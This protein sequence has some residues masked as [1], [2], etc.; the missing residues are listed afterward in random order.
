MFDVYGEVKNILVK[1]I[2]VKNINK[3]AKHRFDITNLWQKDSLWRGK[4]QFVLRI[5][6]KTISIWLAI[7]LHKLFTLR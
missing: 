4:T 6:S 7:I 5:Y 1:N 2:L 3:W